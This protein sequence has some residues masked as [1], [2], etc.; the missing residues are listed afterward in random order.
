M[1]DDKYRTSIAVCELP[2]PY[3]NLSFAEALRD[4][5]DQSSNDRRDMDRMGRKPELKVRSLVCQ[6]LVT[7]VNNDQRKYDI[8]SAFG[9]TLIL[10]STWEIT[11]LY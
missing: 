5:A 10:G 3:E 8:V 1:Y 11:L 7:R 4:D 6:T 2:G 9:F